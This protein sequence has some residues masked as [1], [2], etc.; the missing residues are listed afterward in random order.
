MKN[1]TFNE[2]CHKYCDGLYNPKFDENEQSTGYIMLKKMV[3]E[4]ITPASIIE[5]KR[6]EINPTNEE[7]MSVPDIKYMRFLHTN[8]RPFI[9]ENWEVIRGMEIE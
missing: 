7:L 2:F 4:N 3:V 5:I 1:L 9:I 8:L 6:W